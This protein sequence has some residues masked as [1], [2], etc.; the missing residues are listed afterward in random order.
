MKEI[1]EK[2]DADLTTF[3]LEKREELRVLRFGTAGSSVRDTH[4]MRKVRKTVARILTEARIRT[5]TI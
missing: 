2:N 4:S 5:K 3:L 1:K